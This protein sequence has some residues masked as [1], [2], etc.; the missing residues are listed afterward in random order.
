MD[1]HKRQIV[2]SA[3]S[4]V[5]ILI[6]RREENERSAADLVTGMVSIDIFSGFVTILRK[7]HFDYNNDITAISL[8]NCASETMVFP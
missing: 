1:T 7:Y 4:L 2:K 3:P 6:R 5:Q 8:P